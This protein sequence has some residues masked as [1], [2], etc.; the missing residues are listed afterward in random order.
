[1]QGYLYQCKYALVAAT[2]RLRMAGTVSV[3]IEC[4]D[5]VDFPEPG[6]PAELL[7]V[8]YHVA[9]KANVTDASSE[10]W[11]TLRVWIDNLLE[12]EFLRTRTSTW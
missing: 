4:L 1:M 7:Q 2:Q 5:D 8:K 3:N 12:V 9:T 11:G 6:S 10:L